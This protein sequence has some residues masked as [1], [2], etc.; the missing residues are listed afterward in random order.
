MAPTKWTQGAGGEGACAGQVWALASQVRGYVVVEPALV[1][2]GTA[3]ALDNVVTQAGCPLFPQLLRQ[4]GQ[5]A[6]L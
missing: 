5:V 4:T 6:A 3:A 1:C 2:K